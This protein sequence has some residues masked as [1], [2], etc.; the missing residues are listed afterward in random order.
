MTRRA[1]PLASQVEVLAPPLDSKP[2]T[3][4]PEGAAAK[5]A[6][7][8][9]KAEDAAAGHGGVDDADDD[10]KPPGPT[11]EWARTFTEEQRPLLAPIA[12]QG[13]VAGERSAGMPYVETFFAPFPSVQRLL[14]SVECG[15]GHPSPTGPPA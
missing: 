10:G 13:L 3:P 6:A 15:G 4:K 7:A 5:A 8:K 9:K 12:S 1:R 2:T 14:T 11:L